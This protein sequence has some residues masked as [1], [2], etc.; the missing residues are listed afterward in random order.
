MIG[1]MR[2]PE[3]ISAA[4]TAAET[5]YLVL[6]SLH[7]NNAS[8]TVDRII[9]VFPPEQQNQ[10]RLQL[11][12][13]LSAII[14]QRLLPRVS[15]GRVPATEIMFASNAVSNLIREAKAPQVIALK[16]GGGRK[17]NPA[18]TLLTLVKWSGLASFCAYLAALLVLGVAGVVAPEQE[19]HLL[20]R[21]EL[22]DLSPGARVVLLHQYRFLKAIVV[23]FGVFAA[24]FHKQIFSSAV[25]NRVFLAILFGG[26]MA[27]T[28]SIII[29]GRPQ[30]GL[31]SFT[32]L[33]YIFGLLIFAYSRSTLKNPKEERP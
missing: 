21:L 10:I 15:G 33:E 23:G 1:E 6:S 13:T 16:R 7:T 2:D 28:L 20:Y 14:S 17:V 27:R 19:L 3:T 22:T 9:D 11:A 25:F 26:A 29:D 24:V 31:V 18:K 30:W 12:N 32:V 8:Q 5:G 4:L